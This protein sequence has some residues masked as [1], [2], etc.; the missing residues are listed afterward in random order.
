MRD[1]IH[2]QEAE[3]ETRGLKTKLRFTLDLGDTSPGQRHPFEQAMR[4]IF[5]AGWTRQEAQVV[6]EQM[7]AACSKAVIK[8][9]EASFPLEAVTLRRGQ[10]RERV[11]TSL[12][13]G[14]H[15]ELAAV[16]ASENRSVSD[17]LREATRGYVQRRSGNLIEV[18]F[19]RTA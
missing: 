15:A 11:N 6:M 19:E 3:P 5:S 8:R 16:A 12:E 18:S 2:W 14:P 7:V 17:V 4:T 9:G 1:R 10:R 13:T